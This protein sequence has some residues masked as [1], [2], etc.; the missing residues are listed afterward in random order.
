MIK[1]NGKKYDG[2]NLTISGNEVY[3]DGVR[4]PDVEADLNGK[5]PKNVYVTG[6]YVAR[7]INI[8]NVN[9]RAN[10][11]NVVSPTL[12]DDIIKSVN[13]TLHGIFSDLAKKFEK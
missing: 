10:I 13:K 7:N 5:S 8:S 9:S 4:R 6:D 2:N 1:I 11:K 12:G 3:I